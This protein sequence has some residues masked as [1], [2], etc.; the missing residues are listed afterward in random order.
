MEIKYVNIMEVRNGDNLF[1]FREGD[2]VDIKVNYPTDDIFKGKIL[3]VDTDGLEM[4]SS[5]TYES[6]IRTVR[7][8]DI[9]EINLVKI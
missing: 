3:Y 6:L 7:Y 4:D 9:S 1:Q 8:K 5:Q 2:I